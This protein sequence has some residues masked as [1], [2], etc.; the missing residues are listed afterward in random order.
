MIYHV[1]NYDGDPIWDVY[2]EQGDRRGGE[3][4][5]RIVREIYGDLDSDEQITMHRGFHPDFSRRDLPSDLRPFA[6]ESADGTLKPLDSVSVYW[7]EP[8]HDSTRVVQVT[9]E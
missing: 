2:D 5:L 4:R 1:A 7:F 6:E 8:A 3:T 9:P